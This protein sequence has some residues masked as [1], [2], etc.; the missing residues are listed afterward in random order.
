MGDPKKPERLSRER[1]GEI[2]KNARRFGDLTD[3][4][5]EDILQEVDALTAELEERTR[6]RDGLRE[7]GK[8]LAKHVVNLEENG[9]D[10]LWSEELCE[11]WKALGYHSPLETKAPA[12]DR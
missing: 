9:E 10:P 5:A 3:E 11:M 8:N 4:E 6:E 2:R 12:D 1:L 7:A